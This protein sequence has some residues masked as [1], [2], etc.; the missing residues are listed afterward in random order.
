MPIIYSSECITLYTEAGANIRVRLSP[1]RLSYKEFEETVDA[2][3]KA[4]LEYSESVAEYDK[5]MHD[6]KDFLEAYRASCDLMDT[7][8]DIDE[9]ALGETLLAALVA[10]E[11]KD[12]IMDGIHRAK[13][14]HESLKLKY[15][16]VAAE[17]KA[18]MMK[19]YTA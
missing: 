19:V 12:E 1:G 8:H 11:V 3:F 15:K 17:A 10:P 7:L 9:E 5:V 2:C 14:K 16:Q 6:N 13:E 4:A 18:A